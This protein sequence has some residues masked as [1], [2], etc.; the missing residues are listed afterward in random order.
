ML[1]TWFVCITIGMCF[2]LTTHYHYMYIRYEKRISRVMAVNVLSGFYTFSLIVALIAYLYIFAQYAKS[3]RN[4]NINPKNQQEDG[5]V[6]ENFMEI[7]LKSSSQRKSTRRVSFRKRGP[8]ALRK[9]STIRNYTSWV[10]RTFRTSNFHIP[11]LLIFTYLVLTVVPSITRS[12]MYLQ[13][14][15]LKITQGGYIILLKLVDVFF[16]VTSTF[17]I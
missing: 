13:V 2:S 1:G 11:F 8:S 15:P 9:I 10:G 4:R 12:F 6:R 7:R 16:I 14:N 17:S 3:G 5:E